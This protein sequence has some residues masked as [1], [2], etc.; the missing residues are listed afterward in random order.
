[1]IERRRLRG[2]TL[3]EV[4]VAVSIASLV[5][6]T[7]LTPNGLGLS[8]WVLALVLS[9]IDPATLA[10]TTAAALLDRMLEMLF[11]LPIGLGGLSVLGWTHR[12]RQISRGSTP[13]A[14]PPP[15]HPRD[16]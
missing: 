5:R 1:V 14:P 8:D 10:Q 12:S 2:F 4:M 11:S 16:P 6:L 7:G 15:P 9:L 13:G 3:L